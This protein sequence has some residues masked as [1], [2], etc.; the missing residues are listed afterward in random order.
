M[1]KILLAAL[2]ASGL[3]ACTAPTIIQNSWRDPNVSIKDP[4]IHKIVVAAL[5]TDQAVRRQVEDYMV[6]L[7]PGS[8]TQSY[9]VL[10]GDSIPGNEDMYNQK[11][12]ADGFDG[13]VI[14]KQVAMNTTQHYVPGRPPMVYNTWGGYWG[15]GWGNGWRGWGGYGG[16]GGTYYN[17]GTPGYVRT[18][19]TWDVEVNVYSLTKNNLIYS[20]NTLTKNPGGRVPLFQDV[21]NAVRAQMKADGFLN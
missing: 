18:N 9:L 14:M 11:L 15:A 16:W 19:R 20:A 3:F 5:L 21:C 4:G 10:S 7:Y 2:I 6:T 1:K 12:K 13:I 17:P 8:A